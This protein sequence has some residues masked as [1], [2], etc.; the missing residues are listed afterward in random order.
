[1]R[2]IL[3]GSLALLAC[4]LS[5]VQASRSLLSPRIVID[6]WQPVVAATAVVG[7]SQLLQWP[8]EKMLYVET[9]LVEATAHGT[10]AQVVVEISYGDDDWTLLTSFRGTAETAATTTLNGAVTAADT[11]VTLTDATT[12]DFDV[13]LRKWFI[14]DPN[15]YA[16][17]ESLKTVS[18]S[19]HVVTTAQD[20]QRAHVTG[21]NCYDRVDEFVITIPKAARYARVILN[22]DDADCDIAFTTR[23]SQVTERW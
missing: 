7:N 22:N 20:V 17:S 16:N 12:G 6:E 3:I 2:R 10:G 13:K 8:G 1:M 4:F 18:N 19:T 5:T 21:A 15:V 14:L 23:L 11:T 9:A